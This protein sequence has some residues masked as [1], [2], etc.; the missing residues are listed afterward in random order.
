MTYEAELNENKIKYCENIIIMQ[1]SAKP[2]QTIILIHY[3]TLFR[4]CVCV[5]CGVCYLD[6][7]ACAPT[8]TLW[9]SVP[10]EAPADGS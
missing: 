1:H 5:W 3:I 7:V 9:L 2:W 8:R 4:E 10:S 6:D